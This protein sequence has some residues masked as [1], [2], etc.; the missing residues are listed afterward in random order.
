M[1]VV[2]PSPYLPLAWQRA[3]NSGDVDALVLGEDLSTMALVAD[4]AMRG[5]AARLLT[6]RDDTAGN[7]QSETLGR[8]AAPVW[9]R[10]GRIT[11]LRRANLL[12]LP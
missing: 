9:L 3:G 2:G 10:R 8:P 7:V 1:G 6:T 5:W 12:R 4:A 11:T